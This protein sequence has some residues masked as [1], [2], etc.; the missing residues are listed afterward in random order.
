MRKAGQDE[1]WPSKGEKMLGGREKED[2][3]DKDASHVSRDIHE[4]LL[5]S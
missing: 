3:K 2:K 1:P 5:H 4:G